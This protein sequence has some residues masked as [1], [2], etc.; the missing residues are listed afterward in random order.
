MTGGRPCSATVTDHPAERRDLVIAISESAEMEFG[1]H[2][3][4]RPT[5]KK[6]LPPSANYSSA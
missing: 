5:A 1:F 3:N 2:S 4:E 6:W